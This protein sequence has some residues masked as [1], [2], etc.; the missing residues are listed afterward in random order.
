MSEDLFRQEV[1]K[2]LED[3][4]IYDFVNKNIFKCETIEYKSKNTGR[5]FYRSENFSFAL[6][7]KIIHTHLI[8]NEYSLLVWLNY[9]MKA[10]KL[11]IIPY[12]LYKA[13]LCNDIRWVTTRRYYIATLYIYIFQERICVLVPNKLG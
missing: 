12:T 7:D 1:K 8:I 9:R 10:R 3:I 4:N 11:I 6:S 5:Y 2:I 13:Y